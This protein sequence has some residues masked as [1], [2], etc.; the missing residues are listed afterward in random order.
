MRPTN[1]TYLSRRAFL[2]GVSY[3]VRHQKSSN[4]IRDSLKLV[5]EEADADQRA[6]ERRGER[7]SRTVVPYD[8]TTFIGF[9]KESNSSND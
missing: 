5:H 8:R 2:A 6:L 9:N 4:S 1:V 7:R 3:I